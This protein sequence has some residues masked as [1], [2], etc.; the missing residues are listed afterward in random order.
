MVD[1][2]G[3]SI[4]NRGKI[5]SKQLYVITFVGYLKKIGNFVRAIFLV[6]PPIILTDT[7]YLKYCSIW[8]ETTTILINLVTFLLSV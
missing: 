7:I 6:P 2:I 4:L 1:C 5:E 3:S 8:N